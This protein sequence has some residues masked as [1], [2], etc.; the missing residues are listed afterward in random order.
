MVIRTNG[1]HKNA[2]AGTQDWLPRFISSLVYGFYAT[3][4][5]SYVCN[6]LSDSVYGD[7]VTALTNF[8]ALLRVYILSMV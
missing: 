6:K 1:C 8:R 3:K 4:S 5:T 7:L 2:M